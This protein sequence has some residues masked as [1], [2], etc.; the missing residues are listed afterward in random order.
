MEGR[1]SIEVAHVLKSPRSA[2]SLWLKN[3]ETHGLEG[4]LEGHRP[5]RPAELNK[6][7]FKSLEDIV[8]SGPVAYGFLSGVWTSVM[9]TRVIEEEFG[10]MYHPG[11]VRKMLHQLDFSVQQPRRILAKADPQ[12]RS[13]WERYTYPN[14]KKKPMKKEPF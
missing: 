12:Q 9:V 11:H 4:L 6:E 10:V 2:V 14:I 13:R 7:Q 8:E 5:G 3:Y 1:S